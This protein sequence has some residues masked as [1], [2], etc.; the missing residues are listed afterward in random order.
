MG[1]KTDI[2]TEIKWLHVRVVKR[3][4]GRVVERQRDCE[5]LSQTEERIEARA[6]IEF[7]EERV[8]VIESKAKAVSK[9]ARHETVTVSDRRGDIST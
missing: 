3:V 9:R 7:R 5:M 4:V 8:G 2:E 6:R 1:V